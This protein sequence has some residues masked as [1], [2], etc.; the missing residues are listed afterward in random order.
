MASRR[1][2]TAVTL[3]AVAVVASACVRTSEGIPVAGTAVTS[4]HAASTIPTAG[5]QTG[6]PQPGVIPTTRT[7]VPAGEVTCA[8]PVRPSVAVAASVDDP[9]APKVTVGLPAG[10]GVTAGSGDVGTR[11]IGPDGMFATVTISATRLDPEAAFRQ[12]VDEIMDQS[13]VSTVS[14]QPGELCAYSGQMLTGSWS[15]APENV[16]DFADRIVHVWSNAGDYLVAVHVQAPTRAKA[17][18]AAVDL[19]TDDF[20]IRIP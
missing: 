7:P 17:D 6:Q 5:A 1:L 11:I 10:W 15:D 9:A 13:A 18:D 14:I 19:L 8:P 4:G 3:M 16:V 12:Y 20:E 2:A